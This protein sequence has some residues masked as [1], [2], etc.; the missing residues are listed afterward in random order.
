MI[1]SA[2]FIPPC[3]FNDCMQ[4]LSLSVDPHWIEYTVEGP[5][6]TSV[7]CE[8]AIYF[9]QAVAT[10]VESVPAAAK[11]DSASDVARAWGS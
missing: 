11:F 4:N 10:S 9:A 3:I 1:F 7:R 2:F 8:R 6:S 5:M